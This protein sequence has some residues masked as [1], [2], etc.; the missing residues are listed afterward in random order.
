VNFTLNFKTL[1][2]ARCNRSLGDSEIAKD[3]GTRIE[4]FMSDVGLLNFMLL[5]FRKIVWMVQGSN[6]GGGEIF[7]THPASYKMGT[8]SLSRG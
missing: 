7:C 5:P 6:P 3:Y 8:G 1:G 2:T 4:P